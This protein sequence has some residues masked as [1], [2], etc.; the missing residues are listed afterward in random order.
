MDIDRGVLE[1]ILTTANTHI[2][3]PPF[4]PV[5]DLLG[6]VDIKTLLADNNDC[7]SWQ[8]TPQVM[9]PIHSD[10][11]D[12]FN[13]LD[14][15]P[16]DMTT[17]ASHP[18]S[19][20]SYQFLLPQSMPTVDNYQLLQHVAQLE[21]Q[22]QQQNQQLIQIHFPQQ[23]QIQAMQEQLQLKNTLPSEPLPEIPEHLIEQA[24]TASQSLRSDSSVIISDTQSLDEQTLLCDTRKR[25]R[26]P[27][28]VE[29]RIEIVKYAEENPHMTTREL[30][31][32]FRVPRPTMYGI[33][34][35]KDTLLGQP[36]AAFIPNSYRIAE[37]RFRIL[38]EV[39]NIWINDLRSRHIP[40]KGKTVMAQA[41]DIHRML[42]GLLV[43][44]LLPCLFTSGW[45]KGFKRRRKIDF[46]P[47]RIESAANAQGDVDAAFRRKMFSDYSPKNIFVCEMTSL[48]LNLDPSRL[49]PDTAKEITTRTIDSP[50]ASVVFCFNL[51]LL[52]WREPL[53]LVRQSA[54]D[55]LK[56]IK[57]Y[58]ERILDSKGEDLTQPTL[59]D[60]LLDFD[61][62]LDRRILLVVDEPIWRLLNRD[63]KD[64]HAALQRI[65]VLGPSKNT[66]NHLP[67]SARL[68][69]W[70]KETY[71]RKLLEAF[72]FNTLEEYASVI[73]QSWN[74]IMKISRLYLPDPLRQQWDKESP[75]YLISGLSGLV[76]G[77]IVM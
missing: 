23:E 47:K 54:R 62:S 48:Y 7:P 31:L 49:Q 16:G 42:S 5:D 71:Y 61:R 70:F 65:R 46:K 21:T 9:P 18:E 39:L 77:S 56:T 29:R 76:F 12:T 11:G 64:F 8:P 72:V 36:M 41:M 50:S 24:P 19:S 53:V 22:H 20:S 6:Q 14:F 13:D 2:M 55:D 63:G 58:H 45:L 4:D 66:T 52:D 51:L 74:E 32:H 75:D 34:K 1:S 33:L 30:A 60:W 73:L 40:V 26:N 69:K 57:G 43:E 38:E 10:P 25:P 27:L 28:Q 35:S 3:P 59:L 15:F 44:S 17:Q 37:S 67:M 68:A